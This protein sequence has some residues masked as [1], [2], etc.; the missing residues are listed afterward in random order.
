MKT[1]LPDRETGNNHGD[2]N[3]S[4]CSPKC[5]PQRTG[6][7]FW[8][9][10]AE[11]SAHSR[12]K[13]P[14]EQELGNWLHLRNMRRATFYSNSG[15]FTKPTKTG[16]VQTTP[17]SLSMRVSGVWCGVV[18]TL[19]QNTYP[20]ITDQES[21]IHRQTHTHTHTHTYNTIP[22]ESNFQNLAHNRAEPHHLSTNLSTNIP[23]HP[24]QSKIQNPPQIHSTHPSTCANTAWC[25]GWHA[26][27]QPK[28]PF[29]VPQPK[30]EIILSVQVGITVVGSVRVLLVRARCL[31]LCCRVG[32]RFVWIR[33]VWGVGVVDSGR[34]IGW[35]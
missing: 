32:V 20:D 2:I 8:P 25:I 29:S 7:F 13:P 9:K 1:K 18:Y 5:R 22:P 31:F 4:L 11:K 27:T 28:M 14:L 12:K 26:T 3:Y 19:S 15:F 23:S 24:S 21:S 30:F 16:K 34:C 10:S 6:F 35:R 17:Y 33:E